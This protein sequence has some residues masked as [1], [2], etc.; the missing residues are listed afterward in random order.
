MLKRLNLHFLK[1][2]LLVS[3]LGFSSLQAATFSVDNDENFGPGSFNSVF[4]SCNAIYPGLNQYNQIIFSKNLQLTYDQPTLRQ[5]VDFNIIN[6]ATIDIQKP[7]FS[8][9]GFKKS[10]EGTLLLNAP[11]NFSGDWKITQ[12]LTKVLS[13]QT[14]NGKVLLSGLMQLDSYD[15]LKTSSIDLSQ[16][17]SLILNQ[18]GTFT[19]PISV[20]DFGNIV[21]SSDLVLSDVLG[22]GTLELNGKR[23]SITNNQLNGVLK[24]NSG[25][26]KITA[27]ETPSSYF[28]NGGTLVF[29]TRR[30]AKGN[31]LFLETGTL[32]VDQKSLGFNK[33]VSIEGYSAQVLLNDHTLSFNEGASGNG[34]LFVHGPGTF[35]FND[36]LQFNGVLNLKDLSFEMHD[37]VSSVWIN[38][39]QVNLKIP[40]FAKVTKNTDIFVSSNN[41]T[42]HVGNNAV[43][44]ATLLGSYDVNVFAQNKFILKDQPFFNGKWIQNSGFVELDGFFNNIQVGPHASVQ[45][46]GF[47]NNYTLYGSQYFH[48]SEPSKASNFETNN[49][50]LNGQIVLLT[51]VK[52]FETG[53]YPLQK[54]SSLNLNNT[55]LLAPAVF[56][57]E[58]KY[59]NQ[60]LY[61]DLKNIKKVANIVDATKLDDLALGKSLDEVV[62]PIGSQ[63]D[64][65]ARTLFVLS[66]SDPDG[67][68][69][70]LATLQPAHFSA[71]GLEQESN[72]MLA[73][74][75][76]NN[77]M[78]ELL[79]FPCID[80]IIW[81]EDNDVWLDPVFDYTR[82]KS[83]DNDIG[84]HGSTYGAFLGYDFWI[85]KDVHVGAS[86]GYTYSDVKW[87]EHVGSGLINSGYLSGYFIYRLPHFYLNG[88]LSGAYSH[89]TAD[90]HI[91]FTQS[92]KDASHTN[93]GFG[94]SA[95]FEL[96]YRFLGKTQV[97]PFLRNSY[98]GLFQQKFTEHGAGDLDLKVKSKEFSMYRLETGIIFSQCRD[99]KSW[100]V[101]PELDLSF[102]YE[103]ELA[104]GNFQAQYANS[105]IRYNVKGMTPT[106]YLFSPGVSID[107]VYK[108]LPFMI[109][110]RYHAEIGSNFYDQRFSGHLGY[111]F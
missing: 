60:T 38:L 32:I 51:E 99:F 68:N 22:A 50:N 75:S 31:Q 86:I 40:D 17:G 27:N 95:D 33:A 74:S 52:P 77:R 80:D 2:S 26:L 45:A 48:I 7:L 34:Q 12:G 1:K 72:F 19:I 30:S 46:A 82:Q 109:G 16:N 106:R 55:S 101:S 61:Y 71:L 66:S 39:D 111:S 98:I 24:L 94:Y 21:A 29:N 69:D 67:F 3:T 53:L 90:R 110:V 84:Y 54:S 9:S 4:T 70:A 56:E 88:S 11:L 47:V 15:V 37:F 97:Q 64:D 62:Y 43:F 105:G 81:N 58:L 13:P 93:H 83:T 91:Y 49:A 73:R 65:I 59:E 20:K 107:T 10:G 85:H 87:L 28:L 14:I 23:F 108:K 96:G 42:V 44:D 76:L 5:M 102:I 78:Q 8:S 100:T 18:N 104:T 89:Y 25:E 92:K 36:K 6:P 35:Y 57:G 41:V 103:K 63:M 79:D